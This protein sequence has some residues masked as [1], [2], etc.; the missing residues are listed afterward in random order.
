MV[1]DSFEYTKNGL[2]G[3]LTRWF[4]LFICQVFYPLWM[5]YQW[6]IYQGKSPMAPL[7]NWIEMLINGVKLI[8]VNFVYL[9]IPII[10]FV[11]SGG[12]AVVNLLISNPDNP[13]AIIS[14]VTALAVAIVISI[15]VL[16]I[17]SLLGI[18][19]NIRFA[20][21]DSFGEAFNFNAILEH[22]RKIGWGSYILALIVLFLVLLIAAI[23]AMVLF[24][25][26]GIILAL[27]PFIGPFITLLEFII[28]LI[29][30]G[31]F[32]GVWGARYITMIYDSIENA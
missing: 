16:F 23:I 20:R 22:L 2:F 6:K 13:V 17:F 24:L 31:P 21:M 18:I 9:L 15:V 30:I 4:L 11:V 27:I 10:V 29:L 19:A 5:G 3:D 12:L 1:G 26:L 32:F 25:I 28:V 14:A 8:I 7:E